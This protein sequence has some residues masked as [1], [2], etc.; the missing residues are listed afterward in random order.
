[1]DFG[2]TNSSIILVRV[3]IW[4]L[5]ILYISCTKELDQAD[6]P[7]ISWCPLLE[8]RPYKSIKTKQW[9]RFLTQTRAFHKDKIPIRILKWVEEPQIRL[10][11]DYN[12]SRR[13][14]ILK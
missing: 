5:I 13:K 10:E 11:M 6:R 12:L 9:S 3:K 2:E 14:F 1:M 8:F 7:S 4:K